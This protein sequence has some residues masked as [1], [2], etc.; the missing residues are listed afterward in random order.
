MGCVLLAVFLL[1][2]VLPLQ[3]KLDERCSECAEVDWTLQGLGA[4]F[5]GTEGLQNTQQYTMD[6]A[7]EH[8]NTKVVLMTGLEDLPRHLVLLI[9]CADPLVHKIANMPY[10]PLIQ[11]VLP[12]AALTVCSC[13]MIDQLKGSCCQCW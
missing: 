2:H 10:F 13:C 12:F 4:C 11:T 7:L 3:Q 8:R 9:V 1:W 6:T 5:L